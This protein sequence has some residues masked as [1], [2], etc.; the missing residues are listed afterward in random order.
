MIQIRR[1]CWMTLLTLALA[2][3]VTRADS[4][5]AR[6]FQAQMMLAK[7]GDASAQYYLGEM[8]EQGLGTEPNLS[9][10]FKWYDQ[11][12][13]KG[14]RLAARKIAMRAQ[15]TSQHEKEKAEENRAAEAEAAQAAERA[16][17]AAAVRAREQRITN[18]RAAQEAQRDAEQARAATLKARREAAAKARMEKLARIRAILASQAGQ[19]EAFE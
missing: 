1:L 9:E 3:P 2:A 13:K 18:D 16:R 15:I 11:A 4:P 12:A 6:L 10:A 5:D 14:N 7:R 17:A 8:F 19:P